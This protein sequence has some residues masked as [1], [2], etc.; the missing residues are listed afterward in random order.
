M[1]A[2]EGRGL[3]RVEFDAVIRRAAELASSDPE[4]TDTALSEG[5]LFRI[6]R[7]VGLSEGHVRQA[8]V[9]MRSGASVPKWNS[10]G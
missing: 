7:E 2:D 1:A 10:P 8:L 3:T 4:A 6:A 9:E 5:E